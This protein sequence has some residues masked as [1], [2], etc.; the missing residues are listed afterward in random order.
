MKP[1]EACRFW[2]FEKHLLEL[3][4]TAKR[5]VLQIGEATAETVHML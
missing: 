1:H 4:R 2:E 3:C 5:D